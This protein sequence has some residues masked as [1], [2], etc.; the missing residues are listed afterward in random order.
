MRKVLTRVSV[1]LLALLVAGTICPALAQTE[2]DPAAEP[3]MAE[4]SLVDT[5]AV[6]TTAVDTLAAAV[7]EEAPE[8]EEPR[9]GF[10][11][12]GL[13]EFFNKGGRF[14]WGLLA[15][16]VFGV[17]MIIE[18][19]IT[20]Q[21]AKADMRV[22]MDEVVGAVKRGKIDEALEICNRTRGPIPQVLHAGLLKASKGTEAVEKAVESAG[23]IEMS[24]LERGLGLLATVASV[25]PLLGFLGTV[26]G[27]ISAFESIAQAE[28]VSA[29]LVAS[30]ISEAL[31]T[32]MSGLTIAIP[33]QIA[34]NL[35]VQRID[36][37]VVEMEDS[38]AELID[39]LTDVEMHPK[40]QS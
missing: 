29:K 13:V 15:L 31:I 32:T 23:V 14:M 7:E 33:M 30:G 5:A 19:A 26:S 38:T 18:R 12:S 10:M 35:F 37:F 6:D 25:A 21:R 16:S 2:A 4:T 9:R 27:M 11:Q 40:G 34:H 22:L 3:A 1:A 20:L 28:Q 39:T 8:P 24:F 36:R 17:A